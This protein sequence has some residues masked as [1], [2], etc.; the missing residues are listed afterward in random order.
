[1][2]KPLSEKLIIAITSRA[3]FDMRESNEVY[4]QEGAAAYRQYQIDH[5]SVPYTKGPSYQ[6]IAKLLSLQAIRDSVE[7]VLLSRN[8]S[9]TGLRVLNSITH[10]Q[11]PI[12]RAVFTKGRNPYSYLASFEADIFLS[13][14][15]EDTKAALEAGYAAAT[16]WPDSMNNQV[17]D[18]LR[19]AF[20]GDAV[21]F[22]DEAEVIYQKYGLDQF[23]ANEVAHADKPL[24]PGPFYRF[25]LKLANLQA[26]FTDYEDDMLPIRTALITARSMPA[27][28]RVIK[29]I[30]SWGV[31]V[32]EAIFLA[33]TAKG[34]FLR[35]FGADMYFDDQKKQCQT[36]IHDTAVGHVPH[37]VVN[38]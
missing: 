16:I 33:G 7:V 19:I 5:E 22:S 8:S 17:D 11:L 34:D 18:Q 9:D 26:R 24:A 23:I 38:D 25:F 4:A 30:R 36:A 21:L 6:F 12:T 31:Q 2:D 10:Y 28:T 14:H 1:M 13:A 37:G 35:A 3:L 32:D 27:H 29:T 20:D 15:A